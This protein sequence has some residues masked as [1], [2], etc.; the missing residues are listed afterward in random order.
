MDNTTNIIPGQATLPT[1]ESEMG[2]GSITHLKPQWERFCWEYVLK[3]GNAAD[4]YIVAYPNT[5]EVSAK[6]NS[7]RLLKTEKIQQRLAEIKAELQRRYSVSADS[8][9]LYLSQ[10]LHLDRRDFLDENG[11]PKAANLLDTETA[12]IIDLDFALDRSGKQRAVYRIPTRMQAATELARM[13]G[14]YK[15]TAKITGDGSDPDEVQG[16]T[17]SFVSPGDI[18]Q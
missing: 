10:V 14:L 4:A 8:L 1:L 7:I 17:V 18:D 6:A 16:I 12:K 9:V 15:D 5:T 3:N 13:M 11:N 2:Y